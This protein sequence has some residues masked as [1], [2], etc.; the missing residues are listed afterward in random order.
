MPFIEYQGQRILFVHIPRTGGTSVEHWLRA[1]APLR[2]FT[3]GLPGPMK[4]TPQHLTANDLKVILGGDYFDYAFALVRNPFARIASEYRVRYLL[5]KQSFFGGFDPFA[6]WLD[7]ALRQQRNN[8]WHLDNHL[9]PQWQFL[10]DRVKVFKYEDGLESVMR[11]VAA[12]TGLAP[13]ETVPHQLSSG[14]FDGE[15][16]WDL[17]ERTSVA[18]VYREDFKRFGYDPAP[19]TGDGG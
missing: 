13:P 2:L 5:A 8:P 7:N 12:D 10:S 14:S 18:E 9:R 17:A 16:T 4:V 11:A 1:Q 6:M 15:I 3:H 19:E